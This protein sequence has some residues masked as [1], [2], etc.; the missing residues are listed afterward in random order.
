VFAQ[1]TGWELAANRLSV[2]LAQR[3]AE[4]RPILDLAASNPTECGLRYDYD[5]IVAAFQTKSILEYHPAPRGLE[6]TRRSVADYYAARGMNLAVDNIILTASTSEAYSFIFRLLCEPGDEVLV[7]APS[8]PLFEFLAGIQDVRQVR[9]PLVYDHG[10]QIDFHS[11]EKRITSRTKAIIVVHPNNPTGH[12]TKAAEL[13]ALNRLC[14]AH[15][16][17]LIADEVFLDF[18]LAS[19]HVESFAANDDS[20]TF[21]V[22]GLSKISGL[23]QMKLAWL[24]ASGPNHLKLEALDRLEVI[25]D[26]YLSVSTPVQLAA[27]VL[28]AGRH[29]FQKQLAARVGKNLAELDR[30]LGLQR[31]CSRLEVEGGWYAVVRVPAIRSDEELAIQLLQKEGVYLHPGH[32]YDFP[33]DGYCVVSLIAPEDDFAQ[34]IAKLLVLAASQ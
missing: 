3:K 15:D 30:Q 29:D 34:G 23:P 22:S 32:F 8:Y 13:S 6:S 17:A 27:P 28:L 18:A 4:N 31:P 25:S 11:L 9:Y 12:F 10:W 21:T 19:I 7:P 20:L 26:T 5:S 14:R 33:G 16:L 24:A 2:A 1:R